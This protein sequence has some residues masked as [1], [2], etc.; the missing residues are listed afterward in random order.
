MNAAFE[1]QLQQGNELRLAGNISGALIVLTNLIGEAKGLADHE[2]QAKALGCRLACWLQLFDADKAA[3]N[4]G[5]LGEYVAYMSEDIRNG[6][7]LP[8]PLVA[9]T[10]VIY[11]QA[12]LWA[13][14]GNLAKAQAAYRD[15][16]QL[17]TSCALTAECYVR[18]GEIYEIGK[19]NALAWIM[20][21]QASEAVRRCEKLERRDRLVIASGIKAHMAR[22]AW[23]LCRLKDSHIFDA[24]E[25]FVCGYAM[26]LWLA[27]AYR[28]ADR[29]REY[30]G[31]MFS[32]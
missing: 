27:V 15:A 11:H 22:A 6:M 26:A 30:H 8:V 13:R 32:R 3:G 18:I 2:A 20:F 29:L 9:K 16:G 12:E 10:V 17:S 7:A 4:L 23:Q 24:A 5:S 1:K 21:N 28:K 19:E 25:S 31:L 14:Q